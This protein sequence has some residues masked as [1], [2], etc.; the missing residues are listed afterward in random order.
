MSHNP[1]VPA[2]CVQR[3]RDRSTEMRSP[4]KSMADVQPSSMVEER[5]ASSAVTVNVSS[6]PT[7]ILA[8]PS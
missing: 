8:A 6:S 4:S 2:G 7:M 1:N 5:A 3:R